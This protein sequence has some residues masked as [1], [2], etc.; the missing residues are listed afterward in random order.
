MKSIFLG[1][2]LIVAGTG[3]KAQFSE[4]RMQVAGLTCSMCSKAVKISLEKV[5]FVN[6]V[7]ADIKAKEFIV[8]FKEGSSINF[9]ELK[10][11]VIDAGFSVASMKV[12][13]NFH[14]IAVSKNKHAHIEGMNFHFLKAPNTVLNGKHSFT[15]V[16]KDFVPAKDFKSLLASNAHACVESGTTADCCAKAGITGSGRIYHVTL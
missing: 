14:D 5:S 2:A 15:I 1:L 10:K 4:A 6:E 8:K 16:D 3:I 12:T 9:D 11:A 7:K 13:G